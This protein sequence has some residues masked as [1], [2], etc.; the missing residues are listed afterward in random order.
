VDAGCLSAPGR[1]GR[2]RGLFDHGWIVTGRTVVIHRAAEAV[3]S[4][5]VR[6]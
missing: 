1:E 5:A 3:G 2:R 6:L 4:L